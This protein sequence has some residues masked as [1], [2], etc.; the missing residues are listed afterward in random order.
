VLRFES[1]LKVRLDVS[2]VG[3]EKV[4]GEKVFGEKQSAA[5]TDHDEMSQ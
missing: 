2:L 1:G 3:G 4:F 5:K